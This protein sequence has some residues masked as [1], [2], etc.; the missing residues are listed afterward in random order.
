L[1]RPAGRTLGPVNNDH[2][3]IEVDI[4]FIG[5]AARR[6]GDNNI[7]NLTRGQLPL[8]TSDNCRCC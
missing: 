2:Q 5:A 8:K 7:A 3:A 6:G 1:S 4:Y